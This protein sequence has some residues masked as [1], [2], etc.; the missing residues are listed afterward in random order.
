MRLLTMANSR[1]C[2]NDLRRTMIRLSGVAYHIGILVEDRRI[3]PASP[4]FR[5][6][7]VTGVREMG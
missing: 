5:A 4:W 6:G 2:R 3:M 7:I 1:Q